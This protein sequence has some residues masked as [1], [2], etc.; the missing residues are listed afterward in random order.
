DLA[1]QAEGAV[2]GDDRRRRN[3][4]AGE[5]LNALVTAL[6]LLLV[7]PPPTQPVTDYAH[8]LS[9]DAVA[10]L[11]QQALSYEPGSTR[12]IVV[13]IFASLEDEAVEDFTIRLAEKWKIGSKKNDDGVLVVVFVKEH[14]VR[15]EVGYGLEGQL[16]DVQAHRIEEELMAPRF[17]EGDYEGGLRAALAAIDTATGGHQHDEGQLPARAPTSNS[18]GGG[19]RIPVG[20][21]IFIVFVI[22]M[23]IRRR[24]GGGGGGGFWPGFWLGGGG[25]GWSGGSSGW[26]S[27]GGGGGWSGGGGGSFG[28]GGATGSW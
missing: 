10:R 21:I 19:G 5:V 22:I 14:K 6:F 1:L 27:G 17:R 2:Q 24:G 23:I 11:N 13:A 26:S 15:I 7:P 16:T 12:K 28:G 9:P 8:A 20:V 4:A 3:S 18:G 25:G